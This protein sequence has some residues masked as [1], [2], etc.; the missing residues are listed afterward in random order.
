M[1]RDNT[2]KGASDG[3][4]NGHPVKD[5]TATE[6]KNSLLALLRAAEETGEMFQISRNGRPAA[7]LVSAQEWYGLVET[8]EYAPGGLG[9]RCLTASSIFP[10]R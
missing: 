1:G 3:H 7:V 2:E 10:G 6:A 9:K 4:Y 8:L 5:V